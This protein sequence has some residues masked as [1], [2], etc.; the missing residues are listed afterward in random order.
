MEFTN[1]KWW[2]GVVLDKCWYKFWLYLEINVFK[3][4]EFFG[5]LSLLKCRDFHIGAGFDNIFTRWNKDSHSLTMS[6]WAFTRYVGYVR[7][8]LEACPPAAAYKS[9][10][11]VHAKLNKQETIEVFYR[12]Q[13][14]GVAYTLLMDMALTQGFWNN[15]SCLTIGSKLWWPY[16]LYGLIITCSAL[17]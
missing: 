5:T 11:Y 1:R 6:N 16:G 2:T 14:P 7:P 17:S 13:P 8:P 3:V 10:S 12:H 4:I 9:K 15:F